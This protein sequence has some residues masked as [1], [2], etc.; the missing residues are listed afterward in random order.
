VRE[1]R[2]DWMYEGPM[3]SSEADIEV[4]AKKAEEFLLGK[5]YQPPPEKLDEPTPAVMGAP[6][7]MRPPSANEMFRRLHEDPLLRMRQAEKSARDSIVANPVK[8]K[9]IREGV[10][11]RERAKK[12]AKKARKEVKK[13]KKRENRERARRSRSRSRSS[14]SSQLSERDQK[15][16]SRKD[17]AA[18]REVHS[19]DASSRSSMQKLREGDS[20]R[21]DRQ[22]SRSQSR[23]RRD[24]R[25]RRDSGDHGGR[26]RRRHYGSD[27][28][29]NER[30]RS[31]RH[32]RGDDSESRTARNAG[33][34]DARHSSSDQREHERGLRMSSERRDDSDRR[35]SGAE[36]EGGK[37]DSRYGLLNGSKQRSYDDIGPN[38]DLLDARQKQADKKKEEQARQRQ[39][40]AQ[41]LTHEE[42]LAR[43]KEMEEDG[44]R[45]EHIR[46]QRLKLNNS[47][48]SEDNPG[49][50]A[51]GGAI[52]LRDMEKHAMEGMSVEERLSRGRH[53]RQKD[54][55]ANFV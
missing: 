46:D 33:G 6:A 22:Q 40:K 38:K 8:M 10:S 27:K 44:G 32:R 53:Y 15:P 51:T 19:R 12:E 52:F 34:G 13:A 4:D 35:R 11:D 54:T 42:K 28:E 47:K 25:S 9:R 7:Q 43:A 26:H 21:W 3:Q 14:N 48:E 23:S 30:E 37:R 36:S 31:S 29:K 20:R 2:I 16:H 55:E 17:H 18:G 1:D 45:Q 41:R 5:A 49:S 24:D 39:R 50:R